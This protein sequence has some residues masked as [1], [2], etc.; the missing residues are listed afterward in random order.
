MNDAILKK[1]SRTW[2]CDPSCRKSVCSIF[3]D[4]EIN[5]QHHLALLRTM[6]VAPVTP[7]GSQIQEA[8]HHCARAP[9]QTD[10]IC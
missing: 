6:Y 4:P 5:S 7:E 3:R 10:L 1:G 2:R 9:K 8:M